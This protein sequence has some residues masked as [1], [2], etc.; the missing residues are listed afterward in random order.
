MDW[1]ETADSDRAKMMPLRE[2]ERIQYNHHISQ[3]STST[4]VCMNEQSIFMTVSS[5]CVPWFILFELSI[6]SAF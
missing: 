5:W 6:I 4:C 1:M 2:H 3:I